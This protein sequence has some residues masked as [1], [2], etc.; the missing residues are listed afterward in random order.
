MTDSGSGDLEGRAA[1]RNV[2]P[3]RRRPGLRFA[4]RTSIASIL[5][6]ASA[7]LPLFVGAAGCGTAAKPT[8]PAAT[9]APP[10]AADAGP[11]EAEKKAVAEGYRVTVAESRRF[12]F[13][14]RGRGLPRRSQWRDGFEVADL[15][16]DGWLDIVSGPPRKGASRPGIFLGD[17]YGSFRFWSE[18]RF[19]KLPYDY[20][21]AA[22]ADFNGDGVPDLALACHLRGLVA[23]LNEGGGV[24]SP[25]SEGLELRGEEEKDVANLFSSRALAAVDWN[26]DG[27]ADLVALGEGPSRRGPS[28]T[29]DAVFGLAGPAQGLRLFLNRG[30]G[31]ETVAEK[32]VDVVFGDDLAVGDVNGD[33]RP[34]A[35]VASGLA[36]HRKLVKLGTPRGGVASREIASVRPGAYVRAVAVGRVDHDVRAD[37]ALAYLSREAGVWRSGIDLLFGSVSRPDGFERRA[38]AVE[39]GRRPITALAFGDF[40]GDLSVDLVALRDDG[41]VLTFAGDGRGFFT[42]D[43]EIPTPEWRAGCSGSHVALADLDGD[44]KDEIVASFAGEA[45]AANLGAGCPT[46]GGFQVWTLGAVQ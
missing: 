13:D 4:A 31:F 7:A 36:G 32:P 34:D 37:V 19:P 35:V 44:G 26:G 24:F 29:A 45:Q 38:L 20:G 16:G 5:G 39:E 11:T 18:A 21:D 25:F 17:G 46:G 1:R 28:V 41:A 27:K 14:E 9:N 23:F 15:N 8:S 22:V 42:K 43:V 2:R 12:A 6:A 30:G 10:V 40:D 3:G 33:G